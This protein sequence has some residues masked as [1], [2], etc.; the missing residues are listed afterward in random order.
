MS[1]RQDKRADKVITQMQKE[2]TVT[3]NT[4][5]H[6]KPFAWY[7]ESKERIFWKGIAPDAEL[8]YDWQ[9]TRNKEAADKIDKSIWNVFPLYTSP[10]PAEAVGLLQ[11]WLS[12]YTDSAE[13]TPSIALDSAK[14]KDF[15]DR[16]DCRTTEL[17]A[18]TKSAFPQY[19]TEEKDK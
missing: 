11:Q 5:L 13:L 2:Q 8:E 10:Q 16:I 15:M 6:E 14:F 18:N 3:S 19:F 9:W 4:E 12:H 1:T 7:A 17:I